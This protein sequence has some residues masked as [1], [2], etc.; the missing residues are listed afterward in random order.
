MMVDLW[1]LQQTDA[2]SMQALFRAIPAAAEI[3]RD[4]CAANA[5]GFA[6]MAKCP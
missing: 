4:T 1:A 6:A 2:I 5:A 3:L